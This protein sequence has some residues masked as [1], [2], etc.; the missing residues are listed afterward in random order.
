MSTDERIESFVQGY[1]VPQKRS[2]AEALEILRTKIDQKTE[3]KPTRTLR[4]YWS[5]AAA[6]L[7]V[8]LITSVYFYMATP[9]QIVANRGQLVEYALPDGSEVTINADSKFSFSKSGYKK[10]RILKLDGEAYF[11]VQKG[12]P[13]VV[14][15]KQGTVEVL[16]TQ[17]NIYARKNELN[18]SCLSGKVKVSANGQTVIIEP[19]EK[20]SLVSG[21]LQKTT[22]I[23]ADQMAGWKSGIFH[24]DNIPLI[25]IFEEIE[26]QF[27]V[28]I[29]TTDM[30]NRF[31]TGGFTNKNLTE[32]L[33]M[34]CLPMQ[35][36][37]EI[38]NGNIIRIEP[39]KK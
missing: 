39:K 12:K 32:A 11:S 4:I 23:N 16:G 24:F 10:E 22:N 33:E 7:L 34:V 14:Q 6:V 37:Y 21:K 35:L 15:T 28:K 27:D 26:R 17:L 1:R 30:E 20:V 13:F 25:S 36:D 18:V 9:S 3:A 8:A 5:A 19:G 2:K 38:K 29:T 31:Y